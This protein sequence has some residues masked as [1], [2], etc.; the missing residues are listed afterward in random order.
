MPAR[1]IEFDII[2]EAGS[3][4]IAVLSIRYRIYYEDELVICENEDWMEVGVVGSWYGGK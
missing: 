4:Y 3:L 2:R 1:S